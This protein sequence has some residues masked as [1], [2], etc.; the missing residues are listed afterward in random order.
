MHTIVGRTLVCNDVM[1][2]LD[3]GFITAEQG[4]SARQQS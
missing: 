1:L 2:M 3:E 4:V